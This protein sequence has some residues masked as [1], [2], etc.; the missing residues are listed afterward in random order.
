MPKLIDILT[1]VT[2]VANAV[3]QS[4]ATGVPLSLESRVSALERDVHALAEALD[5]RLDALEE[6]QALAKEQATVQDMGLVAMPV[7]Q[8]TTS[9]VKP[10][11]K[12]SARKAPA[13][14][15]N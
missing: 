11:R 8:A 12:A 9:E 13:K 15:G 4:Q 1:G 7:A 6:A 3:R 5:A 14:K 2:A 10:T